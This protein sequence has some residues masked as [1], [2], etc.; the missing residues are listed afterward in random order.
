M[1][2]LGVLAVLVAT[3]VLVLQRPERA[4]L[5]HGPDEPAADPS[6]AAAG[7]V[8][9][10]E[11]ALRRHDRAAA[12][13]LAG[14]TDASGRLAA[15]V[16][17]VER[18]DIDRLQL[19]YVDESDV[20]LSAEQRTRWGDDA[21]VAD[22]QV[23]WRLRGRDPG[24]STVEVPLVLRPLDDGAAFIAVP[25][26]SG[27]RV[28]MW[29][30]GPV[31]VRET[32]RTLVQTVTPGSA[33]LLGRQASVAV[34]TVNRSLPG[35]RGQLVVEAP[36]TQE[37]FVAASGL[38]PDEA[39]GIA[40]VTTATDAGGT[41]RA[42]VHV[43]LN[44][45]VFGPLGPRGQQIVVSHEATHV[46]V[47]AATVSSRPLWLSEGYADYVALRD[48]RLPVAVLG[49]QIRSL[50]R[51]DGPPSSLPGSA[52]FA[53]NNPD[54]GA[55]YE[56]AWVAVR[57]LGERYGDARLQRFYREAETGD[58]DA[59]FRSVLGTSTA[60]FTRAWRT[61]LEDLAR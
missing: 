3:V 34:R 5:T 24:P 1:I 29:L 39:K 36:R 25:A 56:S 61:E 60:E 47:G 48:S 26:S 4:D 33:R 31:A 54:V 38:P 51:R 50:V 28:P 23:T 19:R 10:L 2:G 8:Q 58:V 11:S 45:E 14:S 40:A 37:G 41:P 52:E 21:Y 6:A 17:N 59:A 12:E 57:L 30:N 15:M 46:A 7:L 27:Y 44:P 16:G 32:P 43:F 49:A 22:V 13:G 20:K 35:W 55:W 53:G 18:L 42:P 9:D